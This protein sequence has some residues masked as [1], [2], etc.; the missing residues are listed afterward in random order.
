MTTSGTGHDDVRRWLAAEDADE[1]AAE[2]AFARLFRTLPPIPVDPAVVGGMAAAVWRAGRR[3]RRVA[4]GGRVAAALLVA[5]AG[6]AL[7]YATFQYA[8]AALAGTIAALATNA[9]TGLAGLMR[10]AV[11]WWTLMG[12]LGQDARALF[13]LP[14][15]LAFVW[16]LETMGLLAVLGL[17]RLLRHEGNRRFSMESRV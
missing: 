17:R 2:A 15:T 8:G 5:A 16:A 13:G 4:W 12:R 10:V 14:Q 6:A 11:D 3:Q 9:A 7:G 1:R